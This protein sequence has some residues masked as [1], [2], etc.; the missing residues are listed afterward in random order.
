MA[1]RL[2]NIG[3]EADSYH[4]EKDAQG[5]QYM[6]PT[7]KMSHVIE[8]NNRA[9]AWREF[10]QRY[11]DKTGLVIESDKKYR[12]RD[13]EHFLPDEPCYFRSWFEEPPFVYGE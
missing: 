12:F 2:F 5:Q 13:M 9:E 6:W 8:A 7:F 4:F 10:L 11:S 3:F 1:T